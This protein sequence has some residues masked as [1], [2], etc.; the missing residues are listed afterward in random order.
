MPQHSKPSSSPHRSLYSKKQLLTGFLLPVLGL[1]LS[2]YATVHHQEVFEKGQT[3]AACNVNAVINCDAVALSSYSE[4]LGLPLG[5]WGIGYFFVLGVLMLLSLWRA[6]W[7]EAMMDS[8]K[9]FTVIGVIICLILG[10]ISIGILKVGCLNCISIYIITLA[11]LVFVLSVKK[12]SFYRFKKTSLPFFLTAGIVMLSLPFYYPLPVKSTPKEAIFSP[13]ALSIKK[14]EIP[15]SRSAY[16]KEGEDFRKGSDEAKVVIQ[17]FSDFQCPACKRMAI[18]LEEIASEFGDKILVVY[19]NYPL[20]TSCNSAMPRNLHEHACQLAAL[21]RCAG[22]NQK[23][24]DFHNLV[25]QNQETLKQDTGINLAKQIGLSDQQ[26]QSCLK[27]QNIAAKIKADVQLAHELGVN[28]TPTLFINGRQYM[29]S[30]HD[31]L[32]A[33]IEQLIQ[34][35]DLL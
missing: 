30:S 2:T 23:F 20:D 34:A 14:H 35:P 13:A 8:Y 16:S 12:G 31:N 22:V 9:L 18:K 5:V 25:F 29:G 7:Q 26:I 10:S 33:E 4:F 1:L 19:R 17:T 3:S 32:K 6:K 27:D 24:W 15:L 11:Q 21:A 28:S